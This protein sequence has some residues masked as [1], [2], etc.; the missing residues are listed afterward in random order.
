MTR[1]PG[2]LLVHLLAHIPERRTAESEIIEDDLTVLPS[3]IALKTGASRAF[4]EPEHRVLEAG[5][6]GEYLTIALP[7][8][9]GYALI[10]IS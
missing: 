8:F 6:E 7:Q 5:R 2:R 1:Q 4:L 3:R 9:T 10:A